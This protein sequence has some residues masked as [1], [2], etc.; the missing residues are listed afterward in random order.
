MYRTLIIGFLLF[1][2]L[3]S[4]F[5]GTLIDL[6]IKVD[7]N[8]IVKQETEKK[9]VYPKFKSEKSLLL[10]YAKAWSKNDYDLMYHLLTE[11]TRDEWTFNKFKRLLKTDKS[12]NGGLKKFSNQKQLSK[13]GS[14]TDWSITLNY[15]FSSARNSTIRTTLGKVDNEYW[16]IKSGGLLPPDLSIFDQ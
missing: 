9:R 11:E 16:Y 3:T 10:A 7:D 15:K 6:K 4:A 14:V 5:S 8:G 1:T 13:N 12:T 2:V